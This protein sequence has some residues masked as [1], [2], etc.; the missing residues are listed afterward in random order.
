MK[1]LKQIL[2]GT[3]AVAL[4]CAMTA[5]GGDDEEP[6]DGPTPGGDDPGWVDSAPGTELMTDEEAKEYLGETAKILMD[7]CN[8]DDQKQLIGVAG[9]FA[10][11][12]EDYGVEGFED[13]DEDDY[14]NAPSSRALRNFF[15]TL[16][17]SLSSGDFAGLGRA[18]IDV[19]TFGDFTGVYEPDDK[20]ELFC[21]TKDSNDLVVRFYNAGATCELT[22]KRNGTASWGV[23][24]SD[25]T[26]D[27]VGKVEIP[28]SLSFTLTERGQQLAGGTVDTNWADGSSM[29]VKADVTA[30]NVRLVTDFNSTNTN[31]TNNESLY[32]DGEL[33]NTSVAKVSGKGMVTSSELMK[34]MKEETESWPSGDG[35]IY[36]ESWY[37]F[38]TEKAAEMFR[39]GSAEV[40]VLNRVR[41]VAEIPSTGA[42]ADMET[43]FDKYDYDDDKEAA[44]AACQAACDLLASKSK[45]E[46]YLAEY[47]SNASLRW[48]PSFY[49]SYGWWEWTPEAVIA[50]PD[51]STYSIE[52]F[53]KAGL[54]T[55]SNRVQSLMNAYKVMF[56]AAFDE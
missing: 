53:G 6:V 43:Y 38:D 56:D 8:P 34:L 36:E 26:E 46:L 42:F 1:F 27:E 29:T 47:A 11:N 35:T 19:V 31:A 5:C 20:R 17:Q 3:T 24:V 49:D 25:A 22:V 48:Q 40:N 55:V 7:R 18:A 28:S 2:S 9:A 10:N 4:A 37:E 51:G 15:S 32:I 50:F 45:T 16:R 23:D 30:A 44:K 21:R 14:Y 41:V 13:D 52:E 39:S 12:Y 54:A 33:I